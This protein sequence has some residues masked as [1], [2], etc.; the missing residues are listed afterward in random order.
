MEEASMLTTEGMTLNT[1]L[2]INLLHFFMRV[3]F[4]WTVDDPEGYSK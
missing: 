1:K 2:W 3:L 4:L